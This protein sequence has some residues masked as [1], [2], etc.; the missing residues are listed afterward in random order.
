MIVARKMTD[1]V[2][3][4]KCTI[5]GSAAILIPPVVLICSSPSDPSG[6]NQFATWNFVVVNSSIIQTHLSPSLPP[7]IKVA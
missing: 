4:I 5:K 6:L 2:S 3:K 7:L 1:S